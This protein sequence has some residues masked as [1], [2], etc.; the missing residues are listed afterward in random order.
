MSGNYHYTDKQPTEPFYFADEQTTNNA[1]VVTS[2]PSTSTAPA[3]TTTSTS[4]PS[5]ASTSHHNKGRGKRAILMFVL[6]IAILALIYGLVCMFKPQLGGE[7][8]KSSRFFYF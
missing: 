4:T 2:T 5:T 1:P 6:L 8:D 7:L 3:T